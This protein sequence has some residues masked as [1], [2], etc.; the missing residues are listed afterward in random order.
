MKTIAISLELAERLAAPIRKTR[1]GACRELR[2]MLDEMKK[3]D[4]ELACTCL[5]DPNH[6][7]QACGH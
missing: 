6:Y 7:C 5:E 4:P 3:Q 2:T 1:D